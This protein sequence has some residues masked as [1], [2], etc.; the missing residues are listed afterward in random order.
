MNL[1]KSLK[2][3]LTGGNSMNHALAS[4]GYGS[5]PFFNQSSLLNSLFGRYAN[6]QVDYA[7]ECGDLTQNRLI[8]SAVNFL[9]RNLPEA[10]IEVVEPRAD[11]TKAAIFAHPL[12]KLFARPNKFYTGDL[13]WKSLGLSWI[14][15]GNV[16]FYKVR[17][18]L[19]EVIE[20]WYL[21]HF[22]IEPR[23]SGNNFIDYYAYQCDGQ[24]HRINPSDIIHLRN[25]IDPHNTRMGLSDVASALREIYTDNEA[26]NFSALLMKNS[27]VPP[28]ALVPKMDI[29]GMKP[30]DVARIQNSFMRKISGDERGKPAVSTRAFDLVKTGFSPEELDL[31][32]LRRLPEETIASLTG[33][34]AV[35]L[36]FGAGL[37]HSTYA[38][39]NEARTSAYEDVIVPLWR[40]IQAELT[41]QLLSDFDK[42]E[43]QAVQFNLSEVRALQDDQNDL[44]KRVTTG[45]RMDVLKRSEARSRLGLPVE[46][47]DAVYFSAANQALKTLGNVPAA[48]AA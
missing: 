13:L 37:E 2:A 38:N 31:S 14:I 18:R 41:H 9:G 32:K 22:A 45:Y 6:T 4:G 16:Y 19:G 15:S 8:M 5:N 3:K 20:L 30:D 39:Y 26:A 43:R 25:G 35:V 23:W 17:N 48:S 44:Y 34:P 46:E 33:I 27:G 21:P 7:S 29:T 24:E 28:F 1:L 40:Y 12:T 47:S 10:S 42:S 11:G 36:Q